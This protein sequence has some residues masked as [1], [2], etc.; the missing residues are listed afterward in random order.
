[1]A[2]VTYE[3]TVEDG[4]VKLDPSIKLPNHAKVYVVVPSEMPASPTRMMSPRLVNFS[5]GEF[6]KKN[7]KKKD[8][9]ADLPKSEQ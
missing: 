1:M 5:D 3:G 2:I 9:N 7:V 4:L 6:F 8:A